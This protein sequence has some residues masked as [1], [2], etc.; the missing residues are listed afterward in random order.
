MAQKLSISILATFHIGSSGWLDP[1]QL[2]A[3]RPVINL[4]IAYTDHEP[5]CA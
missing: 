1:D 3:Y 4:A 2:T 5:A